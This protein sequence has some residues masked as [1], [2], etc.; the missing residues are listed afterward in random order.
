M[1]DIAPVVLTVLLLVWILG[2]ASF[3]FLAAREI[4]R[5]EGRALFGVLSW[6]GWL[7]GKTAR[8]KMF[9]NLAFAW[10]LVFAVAFAAAAFLFQKR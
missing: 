2:F 7:K 3:R 5:T 10:L 9:R 4:A 8:A 6:T 1:R